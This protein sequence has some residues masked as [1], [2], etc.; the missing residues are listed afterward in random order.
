MAFQGGFIC[1]RVPLVGVVRAPVLAACGLAYAA[2]STA[3]INGCYEKYDGR[4]R[5]L[6]AGQRWRPFEVTSSCDRHGPAVRL[7]R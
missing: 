4:L 1:Q 6:A 3:M 7:A 5:V 2:G